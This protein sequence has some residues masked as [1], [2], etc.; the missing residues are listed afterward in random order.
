MRHHRTPSVTLGEFVRV[1]RFGNATNL[2]DLQEKAVAGLLLDGGLD[3][4][5][6]NKNFHL[7]IIRIRFNHPLAIGNAYTRILNNNNNNTRY[8]IFKIKDDSHMEDQKF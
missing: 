3:P 4:I 2:V 7:S 5:F 6:I 8:V 1:Y